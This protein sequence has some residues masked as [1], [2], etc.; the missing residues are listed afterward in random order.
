MFLFINLIITLIT[1]NIESM[2]IVTKKLLKIFK[3]LTGFYYKHLSKNI[4]FS[5]I[6]LICM[7]VNTNFVAQSFKSDQLD[8]DRVSGI[9]NKRIEGIKNILEVKKIDLDQ[10][11][12]FLMATKLEGE[13]NVYA[14]NKSD[15]EFVLIRKYNFCQNSGKLGPKRK[16]W[17][18][19][20]PEG[21]LL[22]QPF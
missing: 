21:F 17:D 18:G 3:W 1:T 12:V 20:I 9:Y 11:E 8:Y 7:I 19:Q 14:K 22:Y 4:P 13:L 2:K 10:I 5:I 6:M 16:E 15:N